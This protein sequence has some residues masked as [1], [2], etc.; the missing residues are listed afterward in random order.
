MKV[1]LLSAGQGKRLLPLTENQPK[2]AL[3]LGDR[4]ALEWQLE[5]L[6][7]A[8]ASEAAAKPASSPTPSPPASSPATNTPRTASKPSPTASALRTLGSVSL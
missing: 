1:I 4:T 3:L 5:S 2:C 8:G 7:A 6:A